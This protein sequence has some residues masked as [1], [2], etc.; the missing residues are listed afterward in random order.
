MQHPEKKFFTEI[1]P[2][3]W[4]EFIKAFELAIEEA[5]NLQQLY[6]VFNRAFEYVKINF[7]DNNAIL[8][9][10]IYFSVNVEILLR[11]ESLQSDHKRALA[12]IDTL[13]DDENLLIKK[14]SAKIMEIYKKSNDFEPFLLNE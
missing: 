11:E 4:D 10:L 2:E 6:E 3:P 5:Q 1:E 13:K 12:R 7:G 8:G 14:I 9:P